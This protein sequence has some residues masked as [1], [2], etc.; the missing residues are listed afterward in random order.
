MPFI[1]ESVLVGGFY[2][3]GVGVVDSLRAGTLMREEAQ[4][5]GRAHGVGQHRGAR[6]RRRGRPREARAHRPRRRGGRVRGDRLRRL[7]PAARAHGRRVDPAHAGGAPDDRRGP[8]AALR[9]VQERDRVP[10]RP[11]HG[12]EHVRAPGRQRARGRLVR[13]PAD[14]A[15]PGRDPVDRG[16]GAHPHRAALHAGRLRP[17]DGARARAG[18]GD[19]GRRVGGHQV[20]DQRAALAHAGRAA[21]PRRDLRGARPLVG[22]RRVGQGGSGRRPR[23]RR[24]DGRG[25]ARDRPPGLRRRALLRAPEDRRARAG[26]APPRASTRPTASC[27]RASSGSRRAAC[28]CRPSTSAR[29]QLGAVFYEAAGWE[30]PHWYE[31][32][33]APARGVRRPDQRARGR[34]GLALVVADHQRRAP[35]D[36]R[37]R[38]DVRPHRVLRVRRRRAGRA[39]VRAEGLDAPDGREA[40]QGRLHAGAHA[41]AAA[42]APTSP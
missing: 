25:R 20:R 2:S 21:D 37:P 8:G 10:D 34:V 3:K 39:R 42:S 40:R 18:A 7:E 16:V 4:E 13:P 9:D 32:N 5:R 15:R 26:A 28:G 33:A 1:D 14:P 11:R 30:R 29:P 6:H 12:H 41:R 19:P 22:R 24:V 27:I 36:A 35:R 17:A 23:A 38:G 31:S